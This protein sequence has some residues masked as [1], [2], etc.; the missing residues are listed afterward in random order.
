MINAKVGFWTN[1]LY[2][3]FRNVFFD[4][5]DVFASSNFNQAISNSSKQEK[6]LGMRMFACKDKNYIYFGAWL[7]IPSLVEQTVLNTQFFMAHRNEDEGEAPV[8]SCIAF[9]IRKEDLKNEYV[10]INESI[11]FDLWTKYFTSDLWQQKPKEEVFACDVS[12]DF[13]SY[14]KNMIFENARFD[15]LYDWSGQELKLKNIS[16]AMQM[17]NDVLY[18]INTWSVDDA[19]IIF[20]VIDCKIQDNYD[21]IKYDFISYQKKSILKK[22]IERYCKENKIRLSKRLYSIIIDFG[23]NNFLMILEIIDCLNKYNCLQLSSSELLWFLG[24]HDF[25][26]MGINI[27]ELEYLKETLN[28]IINSDVDAKVQNTET[29]NAND[30]I[31]EMEDSNSSETKEDLCATSEC[32]VENGFE[33]RYLDN[34]ICN[35]YRFKKII[36]NSFE[37]L[38]DRDIKQFSKTV[39]LQEKKLRKEL[40]KDSIR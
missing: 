28:E 11:F 22:K 15:M 35:F 12:Y 19:I 2:K 21:I 8:Y 5:E 24:W 20:D 36:S 1:T 13:E 31:G 9:A 27:V 4:T 29:L 37:K 30:N 7:N 17:L 18:N 32:L 39:E 26:C 34:Y 23:R 16:E 14:P 40:N 10:L 33:S 6:Q 38:D 25:S 3:D